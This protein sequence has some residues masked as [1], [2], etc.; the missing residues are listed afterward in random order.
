MVEREK[1]EDE[2]IGMLVKLRRHD[3]ELSAKIEKLLRF[4][5][6]FHKALETKWESG[7][8]PERWFKNK[9]SVDP[10]K[11][12][13]LAETLKALQEEY[14]E[15]HRQLREFENKYPSIAKQF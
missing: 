9:M 8:D 11:I 3:S 13:D 10:S 15:A 2:L 1:T 5:G 7:D 6:D 4:D 14:K 12:I